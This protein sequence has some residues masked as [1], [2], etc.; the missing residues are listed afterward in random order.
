MPTPTPVDTYA[1]NRYILINDYHRK[2]NSSEGV[3]PVR[4]PS[5]WRE[6]W[7]VLW[8]ALLVAGAGVAAPVEAAAIPVVVTIHP[9]NSIVK[10]VGGP[11]VRVE[12]LLPPGASPHTFEP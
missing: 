2:G 5:R 9:L 4:T 10:A 6:S 1:T 3:V 11:L 8:L 12:T 7:S